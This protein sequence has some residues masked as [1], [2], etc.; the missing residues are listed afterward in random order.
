LLLHLN[1]Q[2]V[3]HSAQ[4]LRNLEVRSQY[5]TYVNVSL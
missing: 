3:R 4:V 1:K 5:K 2:S